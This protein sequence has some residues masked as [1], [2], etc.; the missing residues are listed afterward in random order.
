MRFLQTK[1]N[2]A[3]TLLMLTVA[4]F[5]GAALAC[6]IPVFRYALERWTPDSV[7]C[8]VFYRDELGAD[9]PV[10]DQWKT[11]DGTSANLELVRVNL[12]DSPS[13]EQAA[14]WSRLKQSTDATLPYA[15]VRTRVGGK[16]FVNHWHGPL[17]EAASFPLLDSPLR[18]EIRKRLLSGHSVVWILVRSK[19]DEKTAKTR[20][21]LEST[22]P[23]LAGK[24]ELPEGIGL[25]GSELYADVPLFLKFSVVEMDANDPREEYLSSLLTGTRRQAFEA[26]EPLAVPVF[27]RGRALEVIPGDSLSPD[28]IEQLTIFLSGACSCQVKEQNPGFDLLIKAAWD[29]QLFGGLENRPPDRSDQ[30]GHNRGPTL[31]TIPPGSK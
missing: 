14:L 23:T 31:L 30:E 9:Q 2:V 10:P 12:S 26:G 21:M 27:G 17:R 5:S 25:P 19:D 11:A 18:R 22:L 24:I 4:S 7:Q 29:D 6:N 16:Q 3:L 15:V 28:L 8:V 1:R 20:E 13:D